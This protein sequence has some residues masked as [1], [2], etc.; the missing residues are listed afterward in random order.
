MNEAL[1]AL[2]QQFIINTLISRQTAVE[3]CNVAEVTRRYLVLS[4]VCMAFVSVFLQ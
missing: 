3:K 1:R 4:V 2:Q